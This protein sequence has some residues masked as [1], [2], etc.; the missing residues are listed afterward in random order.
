M[1][2]SYLLLWIQTFVFILL[3][4]GENQVKVSLEIGQ[5]AEKHFDTIYELRAK[6]SQKDLSHVV[7]LH[8]SKSS[9]DS[10]TLPILYS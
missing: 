9:K 7:R 2:K 4:D 3:K 1:L 6:V 8:M 10:L 5:V